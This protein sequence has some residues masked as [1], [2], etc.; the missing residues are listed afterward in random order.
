MARAREQWGHTPFLVLRISTLCMVSGQL[1]CVVVIVRLLRVRIVPFPY[2]KFWF[3]DFFFIFLLVGIFWF[4]ASSISLGWNSILLWK[5]LLQAYLNCNPGAVHAIRCSSQNSERSNYE[6]SLPDSDWSLASSEN[7]IKTTTQ[8]KY[9]A[10]YLSWVPP[11][12]MLC[13]EQACVR[14]QSHQ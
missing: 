14:W 2:S 10:S 6:R 4:S 13:N 12:L 9:Q 1:K 7:H 3:S 11:I 8:L 5:I